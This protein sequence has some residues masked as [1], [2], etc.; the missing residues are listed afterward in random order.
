[1]VS[2]LTSNLLPSSK[3]GD[4]SI[5]NGSHHLEYLMHDFIAVKENGAETVF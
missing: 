1:M 5:V 4:G 3:H 2:T